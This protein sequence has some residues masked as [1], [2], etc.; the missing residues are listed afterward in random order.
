MHKYSISAMKRGAS[1][2]EWNLWAK[3]N[4]ITALKK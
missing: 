4:E 2:R 1:E 3:E